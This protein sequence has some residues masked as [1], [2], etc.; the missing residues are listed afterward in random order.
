[1]RRMIDW[2]RRRET[3]GKAKRPPARAAPRRWLGIGALAGIAVAVAVSVW[4]FWSGHAAVLA[5][6]LNDAAIE[7]TAAIGLVI[8]DILLEG[9]VHT[10]KRA[11]LRAVGV[12]RGDPILTVDPHRIARRIAAIGWVESVVVERRLPDTLY[13]RI[14]EREPMALWQRNGRLA[15]I[16]RGGVVLTRHDLAKFGGLVTVVG[17]DAPRHAPELLT[18]IA[19]NPTLA[20]RVRAAV[21]VGGRRWTLRFDNGID[22]SLPQRG[23]AAAWA[24]LGRL[25]H[26]HGLLG[27]DIKA[28]DLRLPDRLIVRRKTGPAPVAKKRGEKT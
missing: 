27:R 3:K 26:K 5:R 9:R 24:R 13:V 1:M 22:V 25:E 4:L 16:D 8:D 10:P 19:A 15:L 6:R 14:A 21:R 11:V 7:R 2:V 23:A 12:R 20:R 28:I 17:G 18:M